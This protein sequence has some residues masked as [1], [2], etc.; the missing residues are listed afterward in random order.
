[1]QTNSN[2]AKV[3]W[4]GRSRTGF[5]IGFS[6]LI[7]ALPM[8]FAISLGQTPRQ[9]STDSANS[10][11]GAIDGL[12]G[13]T[14]ARP[15]NMPNQCLHALMMETIVD[16]PSVRLSAM[17]RLDWLKRIKAFGDL[18]H[19]EPLERTSLFAG[20][21]DSGPNLI[22]VR[23]PAEPAQP[24]QGWVVVEEKDPLPRNDAAP[25]PPTAPPQPAPIAQVNADPPHLP[26][27]GPPAVVPP[28]PPRVPTEGPPAVVQSSQPRVEMPVGDLPPIAI[29]VAAAMNSAPPAA[30]QVEQPK[31][32]PVQQLP[33]PR[34]LNPFDPTQIQFSPLGKTPQP[35][36]KVIQK[37]DKYVTGFG[38][39][40]NTLD[41]VQGRA[42]LL[43]LST[44]P[45]RIQIA[46]E[47]MVN[48]SLVGTKEITLLG[49]TVGA[50]TLSLWFP[51]AED[52]TKEVV[53][54]YLVRVF[55]DPEE[56]ERLKRKYKAR[57]TRNQPDLP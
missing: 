41:L 20:D 28:A 38:D 13:P 17:Q 54:H 45:K 8:S 32:G 40:E 22:D 52:K 6:L 9:G 25:P 47:T 4:R 35:N 39:P 11:I 37:F 53:L 48:A 15:L 18:R 27:E 29:N 44:T 3:Q 7:V 26:S 49:K 34:P 14:E 24:V 16:D 46:D 19:T 21:G 33:Q 12:P 30:P 10:T 42:R 2:L 5:L 55:P 56:Y 57:R 31:A 50:T 43:T 23:K 1:M 36:E 51:S